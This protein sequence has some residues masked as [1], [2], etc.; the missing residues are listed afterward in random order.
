MRSI[1]SRRRLSRSISAFPPGAPT[2]R[3]AV[4]GSAQDATPDA[5]GF[6]RIERQ[7]SKGDT[8]ELVFPMTVRCARGYETEYPSM[9]RQ[10]FDYK[11]DEVFK[12]RRFPYE[13]VSYGPLLFALPI[14][15]KDPN[16]RVA[17]AKWQYALD[18]DADRVAAEAKVER[19]PMPAK[20]DW[21]L[22]APLAIT[23]PAKT[24]DWKPSD[25]QALPAK[26][27]EG[28][29]GGDDSFGSLRLHEV[30]HFHVPRDRKGMGDTSR[31]VVCETACEGV[32]HRHPERSE[33]SQSISHLPRSFAALRMTVAVRTILAKSTRLGDGSM[34]IFAQESWDGAFLPSDS[35]W[36][37]L[38]VPRRRWSATFQSPPVAARPWAYWW[39]L[40]SNVT[41]EGITRDLEE[42]HRQGIQG[43]MIFNAGGG[44]TSA[45]PEVSQPRVERAVQ[46]RPERSC[47][48][49]AWRPA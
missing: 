36:P 14:A 43:V 31:R 5:K 22:N 6:V 19:R 7:W 49:W 8:V 13:S 40:N 24:F 18:V 35:R 2:A 15:D 11:P 12:K 3:I 44:D 25:T 29:C 45:R 46:I 20:W 4:N 38:P 47:R 39:W 34:S 21:P 26:P 33:G 17:D 41:R 37:A 32:E 16:T 10:Y 1:P 28:N 23:V 9:Y 27:V 42:M 30:P 48:G